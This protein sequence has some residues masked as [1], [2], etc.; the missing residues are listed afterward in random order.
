MNQIILTGR[1]SKDVELRTTQSGKEVA[2]FSIAVNNP[3]K[4]DDEGRTLAD[5]FD[6]IVWGGQAVNL[7]K[8]QNK[9]DLIAIEG[10]LANQKWQDSQ[11]NNHYKNI[12]VCE[13]IEYLAKK[14][15]N[16]Q[17][18]HQFNSNQEALKNAMNET[19]PFEE[20]DEKFN[21]MRNDELNCDLPF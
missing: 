12:V 2:N 10:R 1:I 20:Y 19:D 14:N 16:T 5:F 4:K 7:Q 18:D 9:G 17:T 11:R 3:Y 15:N 13:M 8:Y 21:E 6:C